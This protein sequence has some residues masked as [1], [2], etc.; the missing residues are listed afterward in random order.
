MEEAD[1]AHHKL[2][3]SCFTQNPA[4]INA[5]ETNKQV[6][7]KKVIGSMAKQIAGGDP[8]LRALLTASKCLC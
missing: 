8:R 5:F 3:V 6:I 4:C 1:P 2:D 7:N